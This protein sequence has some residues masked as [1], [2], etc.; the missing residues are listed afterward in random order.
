MPLL[1]ETSVTY[2]KVSIPTEGGEESEPVFE[3][4]P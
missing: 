1:C 3:M 4:L 2:G